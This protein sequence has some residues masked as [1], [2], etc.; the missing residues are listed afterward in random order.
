M[1][2]FSYDYKW[3]SVRDGSVL[4]DGECIAHEQPGMHA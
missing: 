1:S 2:V 4:S 3:Q